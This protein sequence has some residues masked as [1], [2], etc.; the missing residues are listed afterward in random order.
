MLST[1]DSE[2]NS[3]LEPPTQP[4]VGDR[5][6]VLRPLDNA[7]YD[8]QVI[9]VADNGRQ[10]VYYESGDTELLEMSEEVW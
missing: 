9:A 10:D 1:F 8:C 3:S 2:Y 4:I 6:S 5:L 7:S